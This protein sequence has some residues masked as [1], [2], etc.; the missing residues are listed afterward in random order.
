MYE[1]SNRFVQVLLE[2]NTCSVI[3]YLPFLANYATTSN[4]ADS[5]NPGQAFF[6]QLCIDVNQKTWLAPIAEL[7]G[8]YFWPLM[9]VTPKGAN[10]GEGNFDVKRPLSSTSSLSLSL[11]L[12]GAVF[13]AFLRYSDF[14][15]QCLPLDPGKYT[16]LGNK[17]CLYLVS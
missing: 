14:L 13:P 3:G 7:N 2:E 17:A 9:R 8:L 12:C 11:M 5:R 15:I 10:D 6:V 1:F 4:L 16:E